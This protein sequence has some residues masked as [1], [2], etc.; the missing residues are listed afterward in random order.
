MDVYF[1]VAM[2]DAV[3][4]QVLQ[5]VDDFCDIEH[6]KFLSK[7]GDV[8]L[9]EVD[10]L[11]TLTVLLNEVNV[12]LVL[13]SVLEFDNAIMLQLRKQFLLHHCLV[14]LL[15]PC[16]LLLPYLFHR[17]DLAITVLRH[18][19]HISICT[20]AQLVLKREVFNGKRCLLLGALVF[21]L[22]LGLH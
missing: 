11:S 20:L 3:G 6:L 16:Q 19:K 7:F 13:K 8:D 15:L 2:R 9:D 5:Y 18:Q 10:E 14:L 17:I 21:C 12:G 22:F 4:V 1:E